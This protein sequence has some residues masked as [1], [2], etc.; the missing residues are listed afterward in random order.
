[1]INNAQRIKITINL[2]S[3]NMKE[4]R[5]LGINMHNKNIDIVTIRQIL[6]QCDSS[7]RVSEGLM[8]VSDNLEGYMMVKL[9]GDIS[10]IDKVERKLKEING[11]SVEET[12]F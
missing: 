3:R 12:S 11:T 10:E 8:E 4:T 1:L 9:K 6:S 5:I 7:V 2:K